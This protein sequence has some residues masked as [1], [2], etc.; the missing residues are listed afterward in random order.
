MVL[1]VAVHHLWYLFSVYLTGIFSP[2]V[3]Y[4]TWVRAQVLHA[5]LGRLPDHQNYRRRNGTGIHTG[6][7]SWD[8]KWNVCLKNK[9]CGALNCSTRQIMVSFQ[10]ASVHNW[11]VFVLFSQTI[12]CPAHSCDILVDDNTVMWVLLLYLLIC[13]LGFVQHWLLPQMDVN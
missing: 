13:P 11:T 7:D 5:V 2:S 1:V 12:S 6:W 10:G 9:T 8:M 3:F 4:R